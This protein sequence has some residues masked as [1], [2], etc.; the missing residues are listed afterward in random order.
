MEMEPAMVRFA[1]LFEESC[2]RV[3]DDFCTLIYYT[4]RKYEYSTFSTIKIIIYRYLKV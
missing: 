4:F 3:D 1:E 2:R